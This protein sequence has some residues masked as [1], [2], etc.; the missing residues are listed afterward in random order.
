MIDWELEPPLEWVCGRYVEVVAGWVGYM[1][2]K[3]IFFKGQCGGHW[4][5]LT[6]SGR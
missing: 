6:Q 3:S 5:C 1:G 4:V 2:S